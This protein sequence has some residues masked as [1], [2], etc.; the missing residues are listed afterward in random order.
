[1]LVAV[2]SAPAGVRPSAPRTAGLRAGAARA[3]L[4]AAR[5]A[6]PA[7]RASARRSPAPA[8]AVLD[9]DESSFEAEV[10]KVRGVLCVCFWCFATASAG[11]GPPFL[12]AR[13]QRGG[14]G[15]LA[16]GRGVRGGNVGP[17]A[18]KPRSFLHRRAAHQA[19]SK[20]VALNFWK[21]LT[22]Y[23]THTPSSTH[24][25]SDVPVLVDFWATWCG[26]CKLVAPLM[27]A[28][29]KVRERREV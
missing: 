17:R 19:K 20:W 2:L 23:A 29:E 16:C 4:L 1:M 27:T 7:R 11:R 9:V 15:C 5:P 14:A 18:L 25:Q 8:R 13:T 10:L 22:P 26:P 6:G 3:P 24:T 28:V 12:A 21:S